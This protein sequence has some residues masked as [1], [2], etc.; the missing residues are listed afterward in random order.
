MYIIVGLMVCLLVIPAHAQE[1]SL[2]DI[3]K[4][5]GVLSQEDIQKLRARGGKGGSGEDDQQ[6]LISLL[7]AK[8]VLT[9][10]DLANLKSP[11]VVP[12]NV[13]ER[14]T[15]IEEQ[16]K[17][18]AEQQSKAVE[19]LK[20]TAVADV[21]KNIDWLN[22]F[23]FF[24]D[25]RVR[26]EGFYQDDVTARNRQRLRLR[27]GARLQLSDELEAGV[28]IVTGDPNEVISN[29]Q[30]LTDVFNRKTIN[31]DHAY[32]TFRPGKSF[33]LEKSFFSLT[34]GKFGVN[35]FRPRA[36]MGS[37]LI[38]DEDLSPEGLAEELT[39]FEGKDFFRSLKLAAG[40]W[41]IKEFFP[42]RD[43]Y[44]LGEQIQLTVAPTAKSQLTLAFAD[45]YFGRSDALALERNRNSQLVLTNSVRLRNGQ[46]VRG[47]NLI[48]PNT[49]NP[50]QR[51]TGGFNIVNASAQ[52]TLDTGSARWPLT[53]MF[54]YAHNTEAKFGKNDAYLIG[55][56]IG[57]TRNPGD[58]A[59][60]ALWTRVETDSVISMFTLSDFGRRGGTNVQG[61]IVK[62]DYMLL[63][64][65][66]LTAK[67][68]FVDLIDRPRGLTNATV[69]RMQLDA[70]FAF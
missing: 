38:F 23:S 1:T 30:T 65:F 15:R 35:F 10:Q 44:M 68:Y 48:S 4:A 64:R 3:L 5:K 69:N 28:R 39:L 32:V 33:G 26:H 29:N 37:E 2:I 70:L 13:S 49:S 21:K 41:S 22:R 52:F 18:Q 9:D 42:G 17:T 47:G 63:P 34:A 67:G 61:P 53:F 43:S 14:L 12:S 55:A 62:V 57:Q 36:V 8:G 60:S 51:F 40:Q 7:K 66:T 16:Q 50:I 19:E 54:D 46:V 24:G 6:A 59:F 45:Y 25:I 31:L 20:K 56:G 27:F 11:G 58:W